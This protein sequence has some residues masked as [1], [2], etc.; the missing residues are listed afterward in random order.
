[1]V[2][3][4]LT[5]HT[6]F[7]ALIAITPA[8]AT[9]FNVKPFKIDLNDSRLLSL[10]RNTR[11]PTQPEYPDLG[12]TFGIDLDALHMLQ[13]NWVTDYDWNAEQRRLNEYGISSTGCW[14]ILTDL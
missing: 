5:F 4:S 10:A 14:L 3:R 8:L 12:S 1:M 6:V 2:S 11:L 9:K 7:A 13:Q